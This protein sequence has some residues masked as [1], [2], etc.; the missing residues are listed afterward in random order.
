MVNP[1][2]KN[3][4][5]KCIKLFVNDLCQ[6]FCDKLRM[7]VTLR[8]R[9]YIS[10]VVNSNRTIVGCLGGSVGWATN[11]GS[12]HDLTVCEFQPCI[13][14]CADSSEPGACFWFCVSPSLYPSPPHALSLHL[15]II[16]KR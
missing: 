15:S 3:I 8:S 10:L 16:N 7:S 6:F 2:T 5:R 11:C 1:K 4:Y 14:F 12:G 13:G 9:P